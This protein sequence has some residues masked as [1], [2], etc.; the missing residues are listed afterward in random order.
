V[1]L[2]PMAEL[3]ELR[4]RAEAELAAPGRWGMS[5][6]LMQTWARVPAAG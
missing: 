4:E 5:Y 2:V 3:T 1:R 6:T